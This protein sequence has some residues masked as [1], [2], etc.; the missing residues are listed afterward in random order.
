MGF[1]DFLF[2][3]KIKQHELKWK[4][5][6]VRI[7]F[8]VKDAEKIVY[9]LK[10]NKAVFVS[11]GEFFDVIHA[12]QYGE[13]VFAY[14]LVR[15][16]KKT[17][18]ETLLFDGYMLQEEDKLGFELQSSYSMIEEL[19]KLGYKEVLAREVEEWNFNFGVVKI[20]VLDVSKFGS[21]AEFALPETKFDRAREAQEKTLETLL[22]KLSLD[23]N[24]GVP[25]D[26]ITLQLAESK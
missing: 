11:G 5:P 12:K 20:K 13:S 9:D 3:K 26:A 24:D 17:Q 2:P 8:E 14:F 23:K 25:T 1:L 18:K 4:L 15:S 22:K 21:F 10:K 6:E 19:E 7:T 16:E